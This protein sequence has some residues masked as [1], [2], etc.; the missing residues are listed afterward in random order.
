MN[1]FRRPTIRV[2]RPRPSDA[3]SGLVTALFSIPEGMA[4][5][6][7]GGFNPVSGLYSGMVSTLVGSVFSRTVLMVTTLTSAIA[8]SAQSVLAQAGLDPHDI[9][10]IAM[11]TVAVGAVMLLF[12][13][14]RIGAIMD[15]VSGAVMTGFTVGIA[16]QIVAGVIKDVTGY[17]PDAHNTVLKFVDAFAHIS[18][19]SIHAVIVA[20]ATVAVWAVFRVIK[21]LESYA[22][23]IA[24][25][26][27][28]AVTAVIGTDV[29]TVGDIAEVPNSL[30]PFTV[31]DLSAFPDLLLGAFA[32]ALVALAQAAGISAAVP[33]PNKSR[34]SASGDFSAQGAANLVGGLFGSLPTGGSLSRTGVAVSAGA[35]TRWAGMFAGIW[36]ILLVLIAGSAAQIIPMAVIGGL[37]FVIGFE[38]IQ[39]RWADIVLVFRTARL[40]AVA[41]LVTFVATTQIP[42]QD[43]ILVGAAISLVLYCVQAAR[44]ARLVALVPDDGGWR[45]VD[46]PQTLPADG[47][48]VL[49]YSGVALFAEVPRIAETWPTVSDDNGR[50]ALIL[51]V[52]TLPDVP[53]STLQK[54]LRAHADE[55]RSKGGRF[56]LAGV[57]PPLMKGIESAG[58]VDAIGRDNIFEATD[59]VFESVDDAYAEAKR[60]LDAA[61]S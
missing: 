38:L 37:L 4:Y 40:S 9:G 2:S 18:Q 19:W 22:T 15:F 57:R 25:V 31:P 59:R 42:L 5:A 14:L 30:P 48:T 46:T 32:I 33:N 60:W 45:V 28:T 24:L 3:I 43:A 12:G 51:S 56:M 27:V 53:S 50:S 20:L 61:P 29:E 49:D 35:Q 10:N 1:R 8:L 13:L 23:L 11:L 17:T 39:G 47:I 41:L 58:L 6:S 26:V 55:L 44:A 36:L 21:P 54:L 34:P 52:R 7:I 16:V